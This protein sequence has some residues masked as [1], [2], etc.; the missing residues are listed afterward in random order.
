M[1][2]LQCLIRKIK[3]I[4][5]DSKTIINQI[6][7]A[8][9]EEL[10][11]LAAKLIKNATNIMEEYSNKIVKKS[12]IFKNRWILINLLHVLYKDIFLLQTEDLENILKNKSVGEEHQDDKQCYLCN[13]D[14]LDNI[15]LKGLRENEKVQGLCLDCF[16]STVNEGEWW[17]ETW[18]R[19]E[20]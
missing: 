8:P 9:A 3:V 18:D 4:K 2:A 14:M 13:N 1:M 10:P 17:N 15:E 20:E 16:I 19:L 12:D 7:N 6:Y 5:M 11:T